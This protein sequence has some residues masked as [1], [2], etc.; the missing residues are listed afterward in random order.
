MAGWT[1]DRGAVFNVEFEKARVKNENLHL[2]RPME[3][4]Y[5]KDA[6]GVNTWV[7]SADIMTERRLK[8]DLGFVRLAEC[9]KAGKSQEEIAKIFDKDQTAISR[10]LKTM[11]DAGHLNKTGKGGHTKYILNE[12]GESLLNEYSKV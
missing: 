11:H 7:F 8:A 4:R 5:M 12:S 3:A 6:V 1:A 10:W 9:L 2:I